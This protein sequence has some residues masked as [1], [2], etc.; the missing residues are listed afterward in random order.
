[1][2][3]QP[4]AMASAVMAH[5]DAGHV[6][7]GGSVGSPLYGISPEHLSALVLLGLLPLLAGAIVVLAPRWPVAARLRDGYLARP[8]LHRLA[9]WLIGAS[10]LIHLGLIGHHEGV[11]GVLMI[12]D[13]LLL[14]GVAVLLVTGRRW[15]IPAFILLTGSLAGWWL[16]MLGGQVPDQVGVLTKLA[17]VAALAIALTP[18]RPARVRGAAASMLVIALVIV[19]DAAAWTG[20]FA[21]GAPD[22]AMGSGT[23]HHAGG[24][25]QPGTYMAAG[26]DRPATSVE[27]AAATAI[28]LT[29]V[30]A[31]APYRDPLRAA[32]DG[33]EVEGIHGL[34]F[35][36]SDQAH[37]SDGRI[38]DPARPEDLIYAEG[39]N[40][41]VILGAMF[42]MPDG[43]GG[44]PAWGGPLTV[45][46]AH[47]HVCSGLI[48]LGMTGLLSPLG[49][50]PM[51]SVDIAR[52]PE[53]IHVWVADGTPVRW[54]ELDDAWKAAYVARVG[55]RADR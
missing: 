8:P 6:G 31:L 18:T 35:H 10:A 17:E 2:T 41:P 36:A 3:R 43:A 50:C 5:A 7:G 34:D 32:E 44:G 1:M 15:R 21:G 9:V 26:P 11:L 28:W 14:A 29:T 23:G 47:E 22:M 45:W 48:P 53:M 16:A 27:I 39:P 37:R 52:T 24:V 42:E 19:T 20:A 38:V 54:G 13:G 33:Y 12:L 4:A 40:G 30:T 55:L 46:H 49:G 25:V 51:G